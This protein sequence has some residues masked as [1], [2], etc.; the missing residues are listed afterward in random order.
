MAERVSAMRYAQA[1]F[2]IAG[3]EKKLDEWRQD[4]T[5]V[6]RLTRDIH[7][8]TFLENPKI[9]LKDKRNI[10]AGR[11][12]GMNPQVLN[13]V[14]LLISKGRLA[15]L[16]DITA[17][18]ELLVDRQQGIEQAEV[19]TA[20]PLS[21]QDELSLTQRLS[22]LVGKKVILKAKVD[23]GIVSGMVARVGDKLIDGSTRSKLSV[24][25]KELSEGGV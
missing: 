23:P 5:A 3:E 2:R 21:D 9:H 14:Y 25:K 16:Q 6:T 1:V 4:L 20:V 7:I 18:Y 10:L 17:E 15:L 12:G 8:K 19:V 13:L 24:L 11:L 22:K